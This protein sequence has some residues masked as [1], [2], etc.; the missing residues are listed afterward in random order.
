MRKKNT[1]LWVGIFVVIGII[2]LISMTLKIEKFRFGKED[3][4][5]LNIYFDSAP[6]VDRSS[7]VRVAGVHVGDVEKVALEKG[8]AKVTFRLPL[9]VVLYKDAKAYL[10][11]EGFL[12]EKY[13]EIAPGTPGNPRLES[14]GVVDQGAPP[15]DME[16]FISNMSGIRDDIKE[17]AKPLGD[18]LR[19]VEAKRV[20]SM[21]TNF[22]KFSSQLTGL[23]QDSKET[24]KKMKDAFA[25]LE[26]IGEKVKRGEGTLGKLVT[27]ETIYQ[28][29]KK[30][31]ETAKAAVETVQGA[32]ESAKKTLDSLKNVSEKIEQGEGTLGKL[33]KDDSLYQEAKET[34]QSAKEAMQSAKEAIQSVKGIVEKVEKG[35]GTLGKLVNDDQLIKE[36]EKTLKKVQKAAEGIQEQTP[37]TVL[38]TIFGIFF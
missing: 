4:Y 7:P 9:K 6:G 35:E 10:K 38:G 34:V 15:T 27:D 31:V 16:Q 33:I 26:D 13:V 20:E 21:V 1:E 24:I 23:A 32:A 5:L 25:P 28:D 36:T 19:A 11:S 3:G 17:V 30:T 18:V 2:L 22:D 29:A 12:G 14:N 8:K 37:I